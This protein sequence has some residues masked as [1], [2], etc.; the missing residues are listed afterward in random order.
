MGTSLQRNVL[1]NGQLD[2]EDKLNKIIKRTVAL[3]R[4]DSFRE[5]ELG[6][7][8]AFDWE[9]INFPTLERKNKYARMVG[10][11]VGQVDELIAHSK[12]VFYRFYPD[13]K[14]PYSFKDLY[15]QPDLY[16]DAEPI[17]PGSMFG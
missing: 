8:R 5:Y 16:E 10:L 14:G 3:Y 11:S 17:I 7:I 1:R 4:T 6:V 13:F 9:R 15:G 12:Q 2:D